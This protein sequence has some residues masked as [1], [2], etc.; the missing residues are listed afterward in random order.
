MQAESYRLDRLYSYD[1]PTLIAYWKLSEQY[2]S[3]TIQYTI[4][5]YSFNQNSYTYSIEDDPGYPT[6]ITDATNS[7]TACIFHDVAL[8]RTVD[9]SLTT[10]IMTAPKRLISAPTL[11]L[12]DYT[13]TKTEGDQLWFMPNNTKCN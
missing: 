9:Y 1:D 3:T 8:C 4:H 10:P 6:F 2:S 11:V 13:L 12:N 7:L 5:D